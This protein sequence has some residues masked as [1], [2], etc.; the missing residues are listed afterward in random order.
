M[1]NKRFSQIDASIPTIRRLPSYLNVIRRALEKDLKVIS[2]TVI[3]SELELEPIQVRKD[4]AVT[5]I[6]GKPRVGYD[7][8][9]L[10][11]AIESFLNWDKKHKAIV[12]GTGN[13]GTALIGYH[14]FKQNGM[15]I[16]ASF[17]SSED[18]IGKFIINVETYP[19]DKLPSMVKDES[20]DIAILTVPSENAQEVTDTLVNAGISAIWNF[21]NLKLKVPKDV[22]VLRE[23]LSSSYAVLSVCK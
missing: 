5:G 20:V 8:K 22:L 21:T 7:V 3:A 14:G 10:K 19:M 4:L 11:N 6:V 23:D 16:I 12:I 13:L 1:K 2:G 15:D 18:K 9:E 17:D